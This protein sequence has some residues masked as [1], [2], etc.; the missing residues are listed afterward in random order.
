MHLELSFRTRQQALAGNKA[1][2]IAIILKENK[3]TNTYDVK[4]NSNGKT[5]KD[6]DPSFMSLHLPHLDSTKKRKAAPSS[7]SLGDE[8]GGERKR[9]A[10]HKDRAWRMSTRSG[11]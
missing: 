11:K 6:V 10:S 4:Y 8:D 9:K 3:L 1:G 7:S 2:G 5:E